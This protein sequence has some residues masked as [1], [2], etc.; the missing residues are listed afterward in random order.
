MDMAPEPV[1]WNTPQCPRNRVQQG[2]N[3]FDAPAGA[4]GAAR[5][6]LPAVILPL[7]QLRQLGKNGGDALC[8][9]ARE[10]LPAATRLLLK[11][12]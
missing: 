11:Y 4:A 10:Q 5:G 6:G 12:M 9:V 2:G 8:L 1:A 7:Q 3:E